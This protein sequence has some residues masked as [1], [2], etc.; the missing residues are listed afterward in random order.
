MHFLKFGAKI[1]GMWQ[2]CDVGEE[3]KTVKVACKKTT[4]IIGYVALEKSV[5]QR[6]TKLRNEG[7]FLI[8]DLENQHHE[9]I[10]IA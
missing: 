8:Q 7:R 10:Q 9:R 1:T 5:E 3:F 6:L 2:P 4:V